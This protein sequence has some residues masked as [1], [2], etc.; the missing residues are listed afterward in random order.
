MS[1]DY[2]FWAKELNNT[3]RRANKLQDHRL[4]L[5]T[6]IRELNESKIEHSPETQHELYDLRSLY[7]RCE[8]LENKARS[9]VDF[10][11]KI[12]INILTL[13]NMGPEPE[14]DACELK[15]IYDR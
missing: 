3:K 13:Q 2:D 11:N 5:R 9:R 6:V 14:L 12:I 15:I 4:R 8:E 1:M 10:V 7:A